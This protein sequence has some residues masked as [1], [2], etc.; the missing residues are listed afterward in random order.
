LRP[1]GIA[2]FD[3][4]GVEANG[5]ICRRDDRVPRRRI[6]SIDP[7]GRSYEQT[8]FADRLSQIFAS[9]ARPEDGLCLHVVDRETCR[10]GMAA[11]GFE[12]KLRGM[13]ADIVI[14]ALA[15]A[16]P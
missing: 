2:L 15:C 11:T 16:A 10:D 13:T 8:P 1:A 3:S 7:D 14:P 4:L 5:R 6:T 12:A 9:A